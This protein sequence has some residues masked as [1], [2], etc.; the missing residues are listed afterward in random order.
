MC[1][2]IFYTEIKHHDWMSIVTRF[3]HWGDIIVQSRVIFLFV[4]FE[5][6]LFP[7]GLSNILVLANSSSVPNVRL[8][9]MQTVPTIDYDCLS[10]ETTV[11]QISGHWGHWNSTSLWRFTWFWKKFEPTMSNLLCYWENFSKILEKYASNLR[12]L[13]DME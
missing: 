3:N 12:N 2:V 5:W 9:R 11:G 13:E 10:S 4:V 6:D 8:T 7:L 1:K